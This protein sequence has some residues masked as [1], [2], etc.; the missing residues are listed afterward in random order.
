MSEVKVSDLLLYPVKGCRGYSVNQ[1]AVTPM[2]LVGDRE[3]AVIKD[4]ERVNQKQLSNLMYLSAVWK[5]DDCLEL[6]FPGVSTFEL[7]SIA[8]SELAL[9]QIQVYGNGLSIQDMGD[10][11]ARWLTKAL[12]ANVRLARTNGA[13]PWFLPVAEF[14]TVHGKLQTKFVD[15]API[16]L[17]NTGSIED[18]NSRLQDEVPMNRFR[19]NIVLDGLAPYTEDVLESFQFPELNLARV[20]V[21]ERCTVTTADQETGTLSKEPLRTLSMYRKRA[22]GYAGGIMFGIYVTATADG[23]LAIGD[24]LE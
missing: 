3:F 13:S 16:L 23:K 19:P 11:V 12:G 1:V 20:A 7:S 15:A 8:N 17:T 22:G 14:A 10:E 21:C 18:L 2:G 5:S 4:G 9:R 24:N 6:D